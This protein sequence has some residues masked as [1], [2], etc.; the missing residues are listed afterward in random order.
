MNA[1][2]SNWIPGFLR[3]CAATLLYAAVHSL[4]ASQ[5]AKRAASIAL[6]TRTRNALYRPFYLAQSVVTIGFLIRYVRK[7]PAKLLYG[8]GGTFA[9]V[10]RLLQ[11]TGLAWAFT[12]AYQ[13]GYSEILGIRPLLDLTLKHGTF[14]PEPEAQG[15]ASNGHG[16]RIAGPFRL[17]RHPL[18]VAPLPVMWFNPRMTTNLL[19]FNLV[20][21][22][23]LIIG[24]ALEEHRLR[25]AYGKPYSEYQ[26]SGVPFYLPFP[27]R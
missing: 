19:A 27:S 5:S 18:N 1:S 6:G 14:P 26:Q 12:A 22:V 23:Y 7:Q 17:T 11:G 10:F 3:T 24:S 2:R 15:P 16:L 25:A 21:T 20:G 13:V 9:I 8:F 4:L